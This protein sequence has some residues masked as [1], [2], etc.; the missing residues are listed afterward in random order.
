ME[1]Y[2]R[3]GVKETLR[4]LAA[5]SEAGDLFH[6]ADVLEVAEKAFEFV[7]QEF[8]PADAD[9]HWDDFHHELVHWIANKMDFN[10]DGEI[11]KK[12]IKGSIKFALGLLQ[13]DAKE[14]H[15][16]EKMLCND[17]P[18]AEKKQCKKD[19][20]KAFK[21]AVKDAKQHVKSIKQDLKN[22]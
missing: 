16:M 3:G 14:A 2:A 17:V 21:D 4:T 5:L 15:Q 13:M 6:G 9:Q 1:D 7:K 8:R 11:T 19:A 10:E 20:K 22:N 12:E 18:A